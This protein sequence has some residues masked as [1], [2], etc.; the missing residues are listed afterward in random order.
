[1]ADE[2]KSFDNSRE[3]NNYCDMLQFLDTMFGTN[4]FSCR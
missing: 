4:K 2:N 1:M 3:F